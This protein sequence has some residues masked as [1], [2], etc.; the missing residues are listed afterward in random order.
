MALKGVVLVLESL[1]LIAVGAA[2]LYLVIKFLVGI[3][4]MIFG[5]AILAGVVWAIFQLL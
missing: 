1:L 3:V 4:R 5:F 2:A